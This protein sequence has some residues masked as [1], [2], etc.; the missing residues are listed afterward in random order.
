MSLRSWNKDPFPNQA[1]HGVQDV[2]YNAGRIRYPIVVH[3]S[4]LENGPKA[5]RESRGAGD[6]VKVSWDTALDLVAKEITRLQD[7]EGPWAIYSG[8]YG[9]QSSGLPT[10]RRPCSRS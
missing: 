7:K 1:V 5:E 4:Y 3:L 9:W 2:V 8:T 10:T 6:F